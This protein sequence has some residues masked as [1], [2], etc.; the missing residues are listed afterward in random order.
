LRR[1][2]RRRHDDHGARIEG[3]QH[4]RTRACAQLP[5]EY[6]ASQRPFSIDPSHRQQWIVHEHRSDSNSYGVDLGTE[7]MC[8]P[9]RC[10]GRQICPLPRST[11][12]VAIQTRRRLHDD[13]RP[14]LP[15]ERKKRLIEPRGSCGA[16]ADLHVDTMRAQVGET[17]STNGRIWV[18]C[19][20]DDAGDPGLDDPANT[21]ARSANVTTWLQVAVEDGTACL[22]ASAVEG[23]YF[24]MR[25]TCA[26][27]EPL[28]DHDTFLRYDHRADHR[29]GAG[30][31]TPALGE[32]ERSVDVVRV[33]H[34][35]T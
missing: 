7:T 15:H 17:T 11:R 8:V 34:F 32:K 14:S 13:E 3:R 9:I 6:H 16:N 29:V 20:G 5:I 28:A 1:S 30:S 10:R 23:A 21:W 31:P 18:F 33:S 2:H 24:G 27:V 26:L 19:G 35:L 25:S 4:A 22:T 12:D